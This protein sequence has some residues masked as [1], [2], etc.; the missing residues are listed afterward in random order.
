RWSIYFP[1]TPASMLIT[2]RRSWETDRKS[3]VRVASD[4]KPHA[5]I[6]STIS[7]GM[8]AVVCALADR[9]LDGGRLGEA[10]VLHRWTLDLCERGSQ[11]MA[12][13]RARGRAS[14]GLANSLRLRGIYQEAELAA[15]N[16]IDEISSRLGAN[17]RTLVPLLNSLSI[18]Y[19]YRGAFDKA[20]QAY[21]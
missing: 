7:M 6:G 4:R 9:C 12:I 19:K 15:L 17:D 8:V 16:G 5:V 10:E 18:V 3:G 14:T 13:C 2:M 21:R 1:P 20:E 11:T